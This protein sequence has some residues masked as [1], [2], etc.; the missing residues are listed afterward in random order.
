MM[1]S[2]QRRR[3][4]PWMVAFGALAACF[5]WIATAC[6]PLV[7]TAEL[8]AA[9]DAFELAEGVEAERY[10]TYEF[11]SAREYLEKAREEWSY[12]DYQ[13]AHEYAELALD[14]AERAYERAM[15]DPH[16]GAPEIEDIF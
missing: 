3:Q 1:T 12:S 7:S 9:T 16:R 6:G 2:A 4:S 5:V 13:K 10:A 14:F 15:N 11:I 8:T